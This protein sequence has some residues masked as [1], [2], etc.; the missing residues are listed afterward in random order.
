MTYLDSKREIRRREDEVL[1]ATRHRE[2][3]C[4]GTLDLLDCKVTFVF[5]SLLD[6]KF[7]RHFDCLGLTDCRVCGE[8][9]AEL[10]VVVIQNGVDCRS[11]FGQTRDV[12][13]MPW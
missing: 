6:P 9:F 13:V 10:I 3:L 1:F 7:G 4:H 11:C 2:A 5:R 12:L 8:R